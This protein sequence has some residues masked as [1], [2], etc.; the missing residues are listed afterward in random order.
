MMQLTKKKAVL[1]GLATFWPLVYIPLAMILGFSLVVFMPYLKTSNHTP[2][3]FFPFFFLFLIPFAIIHIA[4]IFSMTFLL[5]FYIYY[6]F[7]SG[8]VPENQ[9]LVWTILIVLLPLFSMPV[10]W[11]LY[12]WEVSNSK[13]K[14]EPP[15]PPVESSAGNN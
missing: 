8:K 1:L 5:V 11:Y 2:H 12:V 3:I 15:T 4:T 10:F 13:T 7:K 14:S 9:Q 6:L